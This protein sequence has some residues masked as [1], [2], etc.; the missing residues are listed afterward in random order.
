MLGVWPHAFRNY[1]TL[2]NTTYPIPSTIYHFHLTPSLFQLSLTPD[3]LPFT[4][5]HL[6]LIAYQ[7]NLPLIKCDHPS[8]IIWFFAYL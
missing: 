4:I 5:Y 8:I 1:A 7:L 6:P 3:H 2:S